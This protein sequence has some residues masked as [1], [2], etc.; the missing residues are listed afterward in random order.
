MGNGPAAGASVTYKIT[1][2]LSLNSKG[3]AAVNIGP[4]FGSYLEN[5]AT[6]KHKNLSVSVGDMFFFDGDGSNGNDYFNYGDNTRHLINATA[7]YSDRKVYGL[8]QTTVYKAENDANNG[9]Y[10]EAGYKFS[11]CFSVNTGYVTDASVMNFRDAAG[12]THIGL[13]AVKEL[14]ITDS[15]NP[16]LN[17]QLAFNPSYRNTIAGVSNTPVQLSIG[18][19]F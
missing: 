8:V 15:F 11:E 18:L 9:V 19:T 14:R 10:F 17:T 13:S 2:K 1:D 5:S 3:M 16:K 12:F 4:G 7:K 6:Y